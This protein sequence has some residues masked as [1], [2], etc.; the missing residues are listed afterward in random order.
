MTQAATA[1]HTLKTTTA[2]VEVLQARANQTQHKVLEDA[3][4][5]ASPHQR[6]RLAFFS[7]PLPRTTWLTPAA[8]QFAYP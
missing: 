4:R 1:L 6:R 8:Q 5:Q 3:Y 2:A 7:Q